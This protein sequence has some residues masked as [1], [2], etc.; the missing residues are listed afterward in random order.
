MKKK[1]VVL[2]IGVMGLMLAAC[3]SQDNGTGEINE[4][5]EA[6]YSKGMANPWIDSDEEGV[7]E[8]TGVNVIAP[9]GATN[10]LYSYMPSEGMAQ[11]N[12]NM[13]GAMWVYRVQP[14]EKLEDISGVYYEW[15]FTEETTVAGMEA[16]NYSYTSEQEGEFIDNIESTR[17]VNWYDA[18]NKVTYSLYVSGI[19][20]N[21]LDNIVYAEN[22][23]NMT[24]KGMQ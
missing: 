16:M 1:M 8:A 19:D 17:V 18:E 13:D 20:I 9:E 7:L 5:T 6:S 23:Y 12:F 4:N 14:A 22:L 2:I 3:G 24:T 10:V 21:G 15:N 11:L